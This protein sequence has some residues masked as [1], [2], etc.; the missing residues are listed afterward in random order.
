MNKHLFFVV[1]LFCSFLFSSLAQQEEEE[2]TTYSL[3]FIAPKNIQNIQNNVTCQLLYFGPTQQHRLLS[4]GE[5]KF[6]LE[7]KP[8]IHEIEHHHL[9]EE[10]EDNSPH[11]FEVLDRYLFIFICHISKYYLKVFSYDAKLLKTMLGDVCSSVI[12]GIKIIFKN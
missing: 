8:Q 7:V 5:N 3:K 9:E 12:S 1:L 11:I 6:I 2:Y 4:R 10:E